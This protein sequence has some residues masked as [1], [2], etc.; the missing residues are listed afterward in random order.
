MIHI[1]YLPPNLGVKVPQRRPVADVRFRGKV[2]TGHLS[3]TSNKGGS[4]AIHVRVKSSPTVNFS[5]HTH[6]S[7]KKCSKRDYFPTKTGITISGS[8]SKEMAEVAKSVV[9]EPERPE[10]EE[11]SLQELIENELALRVPSKTHVFTRDFLVAEREAAC[12][13]HPAVNGTAV[14]ADGEEWTTVETVAMEIQGGVEANGH[15]EIKMVNGDADQN[16]ENQNGSSK[17]NGDSKHNGECL[18]LTNGRYSPAESPEPQTP[19]SPIVKSPEPNT[20]TLIDFGDFAQN[21]EPPQMNGDGDCAEFFHGEVPSSEVLTNGKDRVTFEEISVR[22]TVDGPEI[23]VSEEHTTVEG[24]S[25]T[26]TTVTTTVTTV[27]SSAD[28]ENETESVETT[29]TEKKKKKKSSSEN[30]EIV[31]NGKV[32][33]TK[34]KKTEEKE[35]HISVITNGCHKAATSPDPSYI[36]QFSPQSPVSPSSQISVKEDDLSNVCVKDLKLNY[37]N[38]A[39][40]PLKALPSEIPVPPPVSIRELRRSFGDLHK[41]CENLDSNFCETPNNK[42]SDLHSRARSLGDLTRIDRPRPIVT[43]V[44]VKELKSSFSK[45]DQLS[46]KSTVLHVRSSDAAKASKTFSQGATE[47]ANP[48]CK[49]CNKTVFAMEQIKAERAVW[50]KNCFRCHTCN[51]QLTVDIYSSHEGELYCKPHF[52]E[53]FKPKAVVEDE[54]PVRRR[55]PEMIIRENQ[56]IELPPDVVRASDKPDLGLEELS[57]LNVKSRFQVFEKGDNVDGELERSPTQVSVKR[58]SSILSKLAKFQKKG[59]DVGV[60]DDALNGYVYEETSSSEEDEDEEDEEQERGVIKCRRKQKERPMSF[61]KIDDVKKNWESATDQTTRREMMREMKKE[62][63]QNLRSRLFMGKQGK[64]KELYEQAVAESEGGKTAKKDSESDIVRSENAKLVKEK[65]EKGEVIHSESDEEGRNKKTLN[66]DMSVFEE[67]IS[68]KSRSIFLEMD[69]TVAKSASTVQ[70][71]PQPPKEVKPRPT[72]EAYLSRQTSADIVRSSDKVEDVVVETADLSSKFKF[73]ETYKPTEKERKKFRITPPREGQVKTDSPEREIYRD[74]MVVRC[75]DKL[76][77]ETILKSQTTSKML[78]M[79]RQLEEQKEVVPDGPKPQKCFTPPPD[80]RGSESEEESE[81]GYDED[82]EDDDEE[83]EESEGEDG[84]VKS[85]YKVK[86]EF[87]EQARNAAKARQLAAKFEQWEPEKHSANNAVSMLDSEQA[88]LE[89]TKSLKAKFES[90][91]ANQPVE[92]ARPKVNR[93]V[94]PPVV[95][96]CSTCEQK[97]YPLEKIETDGK[98]FHKQCFRCSYCNCILRMESYTL[99]NGQLYCLTHFK[100]LF[101][102]KGNYDEGFGSNQHKRKWE[103]PAN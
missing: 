69:A 41:A 48:N 58:S 27:I 82:E 28:G 56:P 51:K 46:K 6:H 15:D 34:K 11:V 29:V 94:E 66:E 75:E 76:E 71:A 18:S 77:D 73:F 22:Q 90:F 35:N 85:S 26:V 12:Q 1:N 84:V 42:N 97:V 68:K 19:E 70:V 47:T 55:K 64:M 80:V 37:V 14:T 74:P 79:F 7:K 52:K 20:G 9:S 13:D 23:V 53:L 67:G 86:D 39:T 2:H 72:R 49:A 8:S 38:E 95:T 102:T 17:Q 33:K 31:T 88:S 65:F 87:L 24:V 10:P 25:E 44:S 50:H 63:L 59:M 5:S 89:S 81:E 83:E 100:Q 98:I 16:G 57:S 103:T 78:S 4:K 32:K 91:K 101:I 60:T 61:G 54:E 36:E 93:F 99:N 96:L 3:V 40:K 62:E 43:G 21:S 30:G 45:F 92:K